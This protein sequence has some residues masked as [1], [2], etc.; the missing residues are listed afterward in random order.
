MATHKVAIGRKAAA[1][2]DRISDETLAR[3]GK[4][5]ARSYVASL[6]VDI[7]SLGKFAERFPCHDG[8]F[9]HLRKM[10]SG[11]H[12]VFYLVVKDRVLIVRVLHERMDVE[13]QLG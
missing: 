5:Q 7:R 13:A 3:W 8:R 1:D 4:Q 12:L 11:H 6:R 9:S 10:H 2:I